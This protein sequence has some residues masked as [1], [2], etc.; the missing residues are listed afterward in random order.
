[1]KVTRKDVVLGTPAYKKALEEALKKSCEDQ[2][3]LLRKA[4]ELTDKRI[5]QL[6][7]NE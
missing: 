3:K 4:K 1:M 7:G 5:K 2:A 6:E